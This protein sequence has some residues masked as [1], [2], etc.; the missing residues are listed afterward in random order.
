MIGARSGDDFD[1]SSQPIR[2]AIAEEESRL[3][4]QFSP[5][6]QNGCPKKHFDP[7]TGKFELNQGQASWWPPGYNYGSCGSCSDYTRQCNVGCRIAYNASFDPGP[8]SNDPFPGCDPAPPLPNP[9]PPYTPTAGWLNFSAALSSHM[10]LQQAPESAAVYGYLGNATCTSAGSCIVVT[11]TGS[12]GSVVTVAAEVAL[13]TGR[14]KAILPPTSAGGPYEI[15]A[16]CTETSGCTESVVLSDVM[17]GEVWLCAGQSNMWLNTW[18]TF[19]RNASIAAIRAG[20]YENVRMMAGDS[21]CPRGEGSDAYD[22][23]DDLSPREPPQGGHGAAIFPWRTLKDALSVPVPPFPYLPPWAA[24]RPRSLFD[25]MSAVCYYF[26][27]ALTDQLRS[28]GRDP[29]PIGI[30]N[31][32]IGGSQIEEWIPIE[33]STGCIGAQLSTEVPE[34]LW[35]TVLRDHFVDM[36]VK[37]WLWHAPR[38]YRRFS[39]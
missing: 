23:C 29:P 12:N 19:G 2:D 8:S 39:C 21:Q 6:P 24:T 4:L 34:L 16:A 28:A 7:A 33:V 37:G 14:W 13:A 10:V 38:I 30:M 25:E 3:A 36:T 31:V 20:K 1:S 32:A 5:F 11:M 22:H 35:E 27:E 17:F 18:F 15:T 9:I 26:A